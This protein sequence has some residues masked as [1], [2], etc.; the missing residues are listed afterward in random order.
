MICINN[1]SEVYDK[2]Q[3]IIQRSVPGE[4][5]N[6][7]E[8]LVKMFT[9]SRAYNRIFVTPIHTDLTEK[10]LIGLFEAFGEICDIQVIRL[11]DVKTG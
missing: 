9:I 11:D 8:A 7:K 6:V 1:K 3:I 4:V 10:N 2:Y 5:N